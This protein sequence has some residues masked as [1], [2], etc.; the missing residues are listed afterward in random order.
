MSKVFDPN[1]LKHDFFDTAVA[2]ILRAIDGGCLMGSFILSLCCIDYMGMALN[3][4]KRRNSSADF[5]GFVTQYL[6]RVE[7]RYVG[8]KNHIWAIRNSLVH[9]YGESD[10]TKRSKTG[11]SFSHEYL[12]DGFRFVARRWI[13]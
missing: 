6:G 9:V 4:R 3:P 7:P 1:L 11:F 2:D 12:S 5:K 13:S 8:L 10:A